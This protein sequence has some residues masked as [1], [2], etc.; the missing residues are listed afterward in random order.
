MKNTE[1]QIVVTHIW[2]EA[3]PTRKTLGVWGKVGLALVL[4]AC[5]A[6]FVRS[7]NP[8][9][10]GT[11]SLAASIASPEID[12]T[13]YSEYVPEK[14]KVEK[15]SSKILREKGQLLEET[16]TSCYKEWMWYLKS[17]EGY[18]PQQYYCPAGKST[19]GYGHNIDAHGKKSCDKFLSGNKVSYHSATQLLVKDVED[20]YKWLMNKVPHLSR[21]QALAVTSLLLNCGSAKIQFVGGKQKNGYSVFWKRLVSGKIPNFMVY[22]KYKTPDGKVV[23]ATNLTQSRRFEQALFENDLEFVKNKGKHYQGVVVGRDINRAK[24][25]GLY[26]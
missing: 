16:N 21:N 3:L 23:A 13:D 24:K 11:Y 15:K 14:G 26:Y 19:I 6:S 20:Q 2:Y 9:I 4:I 8:N 7:P 10:I 1:N 18:V 17:R 22:N 12:Y 5:I 25:E